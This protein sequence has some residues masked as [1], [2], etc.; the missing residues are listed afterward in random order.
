MK[1]LFARL[2]SC[3]SLLA[4]L[5]ATGCG[6]DANA[7]STSPAPA[8][9]A[10]GARHVVVDLETVK[11]LGIVTHKAGDAG[12]LATISVPGSI[13]YDPDRYAEVG[14]RLDGRILSVKV[15][16]GDHVKRG[17]VLAELAVPTMAEA[18]AAS[19]TANAA[20][21]AAK[22]NFEREKG[23]LDKNLTTAREFEVAEADLNKAKAEVAAA[24]ARLTALGIGGGGVGG[25]IKLVAPIDG[26]IVK[27]DA[28]L[29]A[30]LAMSANA[31][32]IADTTKLM[33]VLDVH[34]S[35]LPYL[36]LE[37]EVVFTAD[38]LPGRTFKGKITYIDPIVSKTTR[39][40][41]ARVE[42]VNEDGTLRPGMFIRGAVA[43][44]SK[45]DT[46]AILLPPQAV[47]P[48]GNDDVAFVE[49]EPGKYEVR[50]LVLGRR[51]SEVVEV[52]EGIT[53]GET[54][55]VEG[56]FLLRGEAA[57]Q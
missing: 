19:L 48:L 16:L 26:T 12:A 17:D 28:V 2:V 40:V 37:S 56:A 14:P 4:L 29:G 45:P 1:S 30:F 15:K 21:E 33:A 20:L 11:R 41:R 23:L 52:K 6:K 39:L 7:T 46:S 42:I 32:V 51:T 35:D 55:V 36:R 31:F 57:K 18:Q 38:G 27:R 10:A 54:I 24:Q 25:A 34:E 49:R 8:G 53:K 47:Q 50:K 13:E 44:P 9:S 43:L 22:K 3:A 5:P